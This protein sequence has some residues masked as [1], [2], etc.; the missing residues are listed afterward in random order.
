MKTHNLIRNNFCSY[1]L[2]S[3]CHR[4]SNWPSVHM[5]LKLAKVGDL[6]NK[7]EMVSV[8]F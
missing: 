4:A 6:R 7:D 8:I 5:N 3:M 2:N 1:L